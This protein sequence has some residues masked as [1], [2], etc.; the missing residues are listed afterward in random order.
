[1]NYENQI[2]CGDARK[3]IKELPDDFIDCTITSPP[4]YNLRNYHSGQEEIGLEKCLEDYV[5]AL[6]NDVFLPLLHKTKE[7]GSLFLNLGNTYDNKGNDIMV[8]TEVA[9]A[10]KNSGWI[11]RNRIIWVKLNCAPESTPRRFRCCTEYIFFFVKNMDKYYFNLQA[12][13]KPYEESTVKRLKY[14]MGSMK[15]GTKH[16]IKGS[17]N[18]KEWNASDVYGK[19]GENFRQKAIDKGSYFLSDHL[20][21]TGANP[22][23]FWLIPYKH[24]VEDIGLHTAAFPE[25]LVYMCILSGC[26][27]DGLVFDPFMGSGTTCAVAKHLGRKWLGI[28]LDADC[29]DH[30]TRRLDNITTILYEDKEVHIVNTENGTLREVQPLLF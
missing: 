28:D 5:S 15:G 20:S 21:E 13:A 30:T 11:L 23:D 6:A 25:E 7:S 29:V 1:M 16:T 18:K 24:Q 12:V 22:G 14:K 27:P 19:M 26:P 8:E 17:G 4:Y 9:R 10:L 2:V 3:I